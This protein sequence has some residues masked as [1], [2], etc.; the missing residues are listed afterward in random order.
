MEIP[1]LDRNLFG[2]FLFSIKGKTLK[3][4]SSFKNV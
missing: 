2:W 4:V 3:I 1:W